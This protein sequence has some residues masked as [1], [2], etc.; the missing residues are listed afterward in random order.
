MTCEG[1]GASI[2]RHRILE[3][4]TAMIVATCGS[5][6]PERERVR[7]AAGYSAPDHVDHFHAMP[8]LLQ[9]L[10]EL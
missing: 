6:I 1:L 3:S 4:S 9:R 5:T 10:L 2:D 7:C 8:E